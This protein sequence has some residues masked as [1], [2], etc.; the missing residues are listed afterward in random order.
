MATTTAKD[1]RRW[2]IGVP[3]N[4]VVEDDVFDAEGEPYDEETTGDIEAEPNPIWSGDDA[5]TD[6][7][8]DEMPED[9]AVAFREWLTENEP[10]LAGPMVAIEGASV[11]GDMAENQDEV[12]ALMAAEQ[13]LTPEYPTFSKEQREAF[14]ELVAE[15]AVAKKAPLVLAI[16]A[17]KCRRES[18]EEA[19]ELDEEELEEESTEDDSATTA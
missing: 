6:A 10:E 18:V 4:A 2:A 13:F 1:L 9:E 8:L 12:E 15:L 11:D 5:R 17:L 3:H 7:E 14:V 19:E 16:A